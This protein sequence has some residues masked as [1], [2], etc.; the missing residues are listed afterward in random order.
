[1]RARIKA[2]KFPSGGNGRADL[3]HTV[4]LHPTWSEMMHE[5]VLDA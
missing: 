3:M 2:G 1:M 4:L 5:S